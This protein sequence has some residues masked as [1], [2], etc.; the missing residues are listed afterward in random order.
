VEQLDEQ[1]TSMQFGGWVVVVAIVDST[2]VNVATV[3]KTIVVKIM[4]ATMEGEM[5]EGVVEAS[6]WR[7]DG[8]LRR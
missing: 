6:G 4:G 5:E 3:P 2:N 7:G 1:P 8:S